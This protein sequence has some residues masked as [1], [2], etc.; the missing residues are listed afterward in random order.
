MNFFDI[1]TTWTN[2]ELTL[3]KLC[4]ASA[5]LLAG[6]FFHAFI[7]QHYL[8]IVAIFCITVVWTPYLWLVKM[9]NR[10]R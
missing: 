7:R 5:Y 4:L 2:S 9:K 10:P 8:V 6:A 3:V 1:K